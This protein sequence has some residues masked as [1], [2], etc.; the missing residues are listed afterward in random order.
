WQLLSLAVVVLVIVDPGLTAN[1]G[2]QLSVVATAGVLVGARWPVKGLVRRALAVTIGAQIA[3]APLLTLHFGTVPLLSPLVNLLAAPLV[4]AAT[5]AGAVGTVGV[6]FLIGPAAWLANVVLGLARAASGWPQ[7]SATALGVVLGLALVLALAPRLRVYTALPVAAVLV[8]V[9]VLPRA[10]LSEAAVA[11]LDVGQGDA[12]LIHG[13]GDRYALVDGGPDPALLI[14]RLRDYG[15]N[16]LELVV[17]SHVHADHATGLTAL[18]GLVPIAQVWAAAEPHET[19]AS[20]ELFAALAAQE[21]T[22]ITP[23]VGERM[24]LGSLELVVEGPVRRY[25]SPNDQ[26]VVLTVVGRQRT[27]LLTG[28]IE[29][30]AQEDLRFLRADVLKV[31]HQGGATSDAAWLKGVGADLAIISVGPNDYGHPAGWVIDTLESSGARVMRT[32]ED[33]DVVVDLGS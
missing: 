28:D 33:R 25:A 24:S 12:I 11:V 23:R 9:M 14:S 20:E 18:V 32:D 29:T 26:S 31:P 3:V 13:D 17:L 21:I 15:V 5:M 6:S 10:T 27:M 30:Y 7:L 16:S 1:V 19:P 2:F 22:P 8:V 4:T